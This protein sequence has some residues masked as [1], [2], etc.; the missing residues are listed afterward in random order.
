MQTFLY[1]YQSI[2]YIQKP[3]YIIYTLFLEKVPKK[4]LKKR[5]NLKKIKIYLQALNICTSFLLN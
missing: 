1:N 5:K 3:L 4:N 2:I